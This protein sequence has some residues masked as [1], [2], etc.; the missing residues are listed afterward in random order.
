MAQLVI[1]WC[2]HFYG[3][4]KYLLSINYQKIWKTIHLL[5]CQ[6]LSISTP[7]YVDSWTMNST[8]T[9]VWNLGISFEG[10]KKKSC[11]TAACDKSFKSLENHFYAFSLVFFLFSNG[12]LCDNRRVFT[13]F[14]VQERKKENGA[15]LTV[16]NTMYFKILAS[17]M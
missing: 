13:S 7:P 8:V 5:R 2:I 16:I 14:G 12:L 17:S 6:V 11:H 3:C 4:D 10:E 15:K 1:S 9:S